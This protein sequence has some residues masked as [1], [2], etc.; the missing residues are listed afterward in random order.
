MLIFFCFN[1][2]KKDVET[3]KD[4]IRKAAALI[5]ESDSILIGAGAGMGVD[6]GLP[7]FRGNEGFWNAYPP[8]KKLGLNFYQMANPDGFSS[9]P[10]FAWGF[11]GHRLNLYR[12][13]SPHRGFSILKKWSGM[14]KE[15]YFVFTSNV[16]GHFQKA[17]FPDEKVEECH[18]SIHFLQCT[19]PSC[20]DVWDGSD[21]NI[22]VNSVTMRADGELPICSGCGSV[23]RPNILMFGDWNWVSDRTHFQHQRLLEWRSGLESKK[24]VIIECGA[25]TAVPTVRY[26]SE[27]FLGMFDSSLIRINV[28]EHHVPPGNIGIPGGAAEVLESIDSIIS[29]QIS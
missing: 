8:Y 3:D 5:C 13:T 28:R 21:V 6:S 29:G 7:D 2:K 9:D 18:G 15:D 16:D 10:P 14:K 26:M 4:L 27:K 19:S 11:Y 25:G 23:A 20:T 17:G 12:K 22:N 1:V 24:L